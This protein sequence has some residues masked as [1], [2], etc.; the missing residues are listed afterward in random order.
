MALV[1]LLVLAGTPVTDGPEIA[2]EITPEATAQRPGP[3]QTEPP[4]GPFK[5]PPLA[6]GRPILRNPF[7]LPALP[8][9]DTRSSQVLAGASQPRRQPERVVCTMRI[10][11][12]DPSI[13]P[14]ILVKLPAGPPDPIVRDDLARC[15]E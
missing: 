12:G 7:G 11:K 10:V 2:A 9:L 14:G 3:A 6:L 8:Q 4:E 1:F 13:D 15:V 5:T